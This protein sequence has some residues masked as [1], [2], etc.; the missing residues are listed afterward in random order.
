MIC[1]YLED[2]KGVGASNLRHLEAMGVFVSSQ[3]EHTP[4]IAGGDWQASPEA[5]ASTGFAGRAGMAIAASRHP[6]G[7]YRE[8]RTT[9]ELDFFLVTNDLSMGLDSVATIEG[10]GVRPH[11][12]VRLT[13]RPKLAS[14]RAL[15]VR[16]PP[17]LPVQRM[18]G[19]LRQPPAWCSLAAR[20]RQLVERA[21]NAD[22]TCGSDFVAAYSN[23][24]A[25]WADLA[26][27]EII[28]ATGAHFSGTRKNS[29][30]AGR[31]RGS[32]GGQFSLRSLGAR[33]VLTRRPDGATP[34]RMR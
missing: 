13:F 32:C 29:G 18:I 22:D 14:V 1:A 15:H 16:N 25:E 12:P 31:R 24:Y 7:T 30:C 33:R 27:R 9:S 28:E 4:C 19:P 20:A 34:R 17:R 26:E 2:G 21:A 3:G 8:T 11:V 23:L 5:I 6:R 10:A